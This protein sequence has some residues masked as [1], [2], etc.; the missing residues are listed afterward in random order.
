MDKALLRQMIVEYFSEAELRELCFDLEV[1]YE[2][3][4]G[5]S[6][7][8]KVIDLISYMERRGRLVEMVVMCQ[9]SRP[10]VDWPEF[11]TD[12]PPAAAPMSPAMVTPPGN[13]FTY[14]NPISD[15]GRFFGRQREVEQVFSRLR[16]P[17]HESS[18]L[19][20]GRRV[21]KTS[22]LKYL[23][24]PEVRSRYGLDPG[25][26]TFVYVDLQM[27]D[28]STMP[29]R[30]W[31]HWLGKISKVCPD[32]ELKNRFLEAQEAGPI[33]NFAL[34]DL[35]D[36]VDAKGQHIVLLL[37]EF[38]KVTANPNFDT[39][40]FYGLRS[41]AIQHN[42]SLVTSSRHELIELT[43]S[44]AIRSSPF[45]NIFANINVGLFSQAEARTLMA[46]SLAGTPVAFTEADIETLLRVGGRYPF[47]LQA[48]CHFLF[49]AI[50]DGLEETARLTYL[51]EK[52]APEAAPHLTHYWQDSSDHE[53]IL[54]LVLAE[55]AATVGQEWQGVELP[56]VNALY[57][58]ADQ[59]LPRLEKR[60]LIAQEQGRYALFNIPF[61]RW[62]LDE[63]ANPAEDDRSFVPQTQTDDQL[64]DRLAE[65]TRELMNQIMLQVGD[66]YR[67]LILT[68]L[69]NSL[70]PDMVVGMLQDTF[71]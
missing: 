52:F 16:N 68:W 53:Q 64:I 55:L 69:S 33:D 7:S 47:F 48:A 23:A 40:F 60:S 19:V 50:A 62:I 34:A 3:L 31:Q 21:G 12:Q 20:G 30:L 25:Q 27:L 38:E 9:Q 63:I 37:D 61:G 42:L 22:L 18:S 11:T 51:Q 29:E 54:L 57:T 49:E 41:L 1:P 56:A 15:P 58:R 46:S 4:P 26:Y 65:E 71:M 43:H 35:F 14:G 24:H 66:K 39:G 6:K 8:E 5:P 36:A 67:R 44:E 59:M 2:D 28:D 70:E 10:H 13:P 32:D 17:E 45:F